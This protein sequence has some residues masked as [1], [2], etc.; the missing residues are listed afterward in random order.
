M[1][2]AQPA[3]REDELIKRLGMAVAKKWG[4][5]PPFAQ[6]EILDQACE[7]PDGAA[8]ADVREALQTFL[9]PDELNGSPLE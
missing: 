6:D 2:N 5:I 1:N 3:K 9:E 8:G 7:I 4:S